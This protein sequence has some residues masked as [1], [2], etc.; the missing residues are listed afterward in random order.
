MLSPT[1]HLSFYYFF[2][3]R[4]RHTRCLNDW[5][6]DVCS[7]DLPV[8]TSYCES[9]PMPLSKRLLD[10]T[11]ICLALLC[12]LPIALIIALI[13]RV[14]SSGPIFSKQERVGYRG[15]RFMCFKFRTICID[16]E[17]SAH[18]DSFR[19]FARLNQPIVQFSMKDDPRTFLF[20]K[21]NNRL[22]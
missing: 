6:S 5:S 15:R 18:E 14:V 9:Q 7:S 21:L 2:S 11:L 19:D 4:R 17:T 3:S 22:V 8:S 1:P 16:V 13:F 12:L 20:K 10:L